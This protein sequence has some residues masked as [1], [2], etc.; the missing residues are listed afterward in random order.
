MEEAKKI[1]CYKRLMYKQFVQ[2][3]GLS[4]PQFLSQICRNVSRTFVQLCKETPNH[5]LVSSWRAVLIR[6]LALLIWKT[7]IEKK[8]RTLKCLN[9]TIRL[10]KVTENGAFALIFRLHRGGF[11]SSK[12][13]THG[14]LP[15]K[16][17]K[18]ANVR[19]S[20]RRRGG[21][22]GG[23]RCTQLELELRSLNEG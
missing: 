4:G 13:P 12:V 19:G 1:K 6:I 18:N 8:N 22:R 15:S 14:N 3:S 7:L 2:V 17:K 16:A 9:G 5:K 10:Y 23:G 11:D 20:A 21:G